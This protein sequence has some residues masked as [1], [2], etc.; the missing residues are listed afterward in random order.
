MPNLLAVALLLTSTDARAF[1]P[2]DISLSSMAVYQDQ[3][4]DADVIGAAYKELVLE[5]GSSLANKPG[6]P[7]ET[8]GINGFGLGFDST[9]SFIHADGEVNEPS[10][11][12]RAHVDGTPSNL[13]WVPRIVLQKGLPLS[14][15]IGASVGYISFS[16]QTVVSGWGRFGL[17][18]GY[19]KAPDINLQFG[20]AGYIGNEELELGV[21]DFSF[22]IGYGLPF[23]VIVGINETKFQPFAGVGRLYIHS[24]PRLSEEEQTELGVGPLSG[25][26]KG[27]GFD[28]ELRPLQVQGGFQLTKGNFQFHSAVAYSIGTLASVN[29][30]LGFDY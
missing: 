10:A 5:M 21:M 25:F 8:L 29:L 1:F 4:V 12:E 9:F 24:A 19:R 15:E 17:L 18:E 11:W 26:K 14:A 27:E 3:S 23:G 7:V 22:N 6:A 30:G 28:E 20:Y 13:M 2:D 16:R